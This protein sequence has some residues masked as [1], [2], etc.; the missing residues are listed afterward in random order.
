MIRFGISVHGIAAIGRRFSRVPRTIGKHVKA[1]LRNVG[2]L[3]QREARRNAKFLRGDLERSIMFHVGENYVDILVPL[4]TP[5]GPYAALQHDKIRG[6]GKKTRQK[7]GRA[8]W[9]FIERA[10]E[11][12]ADQIEDMIANAAFEDV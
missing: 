12:E 7:G 3:V 9:K 1:E 2:M 6:R 8:G 11:D 5:A 4:N 10:I